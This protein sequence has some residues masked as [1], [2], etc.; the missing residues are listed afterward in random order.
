MLPALAS[1]EDLEARI[2]AVSDPAR[3]QAAL[4]DASTT[5]RAFTRRS[6]AVDDALALPSGADSWKAD[7]LVKVCLSVAQ[8]ILDNPEGFTRES[9]GSW[10]GERSNS[11][12]DAYL[13]KSEQRDLATVIGTGGVW[14]MPLTRSIDDAPE[15]IDCVNAD[16]GAPSTMPFTYEPLS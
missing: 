2:G 10:S 4:D 13:T 15:L 3:A 11:S 12:A 7:V 6:W 14:A 5:I 8:R 9:V 16:S 1:I